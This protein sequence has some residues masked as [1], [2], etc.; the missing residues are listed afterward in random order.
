MKTATYI[1]YYFYDIKENKIYQVSCNYKRSVDDYY[2]VT[3]R[4]TRD[5]LCTTWLMQN[6]IDTAERIYSDSFRSSGYRIY[7][8][9]DDINYICNKIHDVIEKEIEEEITRLDAVKCSLNKIEKKM[10]DLKNANITPPN[11]VARLEKP[12]LSYWTEL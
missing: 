8:F 7:S 1:Y 9:N 5:T 2:E 6:E 4:D 10:E 11:K 3:F 12:N